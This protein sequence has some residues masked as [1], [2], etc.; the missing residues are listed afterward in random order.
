[1]TGKQRLPDA[2]VA[3]HNVL[4]AAS[5]PHAIGGA[6]ALSYHAKPRGTVE[7]DLDIFE[8]PNEARRTL[9]ALERA[10]AQVPSPIDVADHL[11]V[12]GISCTWRDI[13]VDLFFAFDDEYFAVVESRVAHFPFVDSSEA[14]HDLPFISAEDLAVFKIRFNRPKDWIDLQALADAGPLDVDYVTQWVLYLGGERE[15]PRLRRFL[16]MTSS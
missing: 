2:V 10:G 11:P 8:P 14:V 3:V 13:R 5:I 7:M 16:A 6:I 15:W 12:A 1:M 9:H 4:D